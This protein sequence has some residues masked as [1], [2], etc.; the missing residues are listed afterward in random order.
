MEN[1]QTT[2]ITNTNSILQVCFPVSEGIIT[3][4]YTYVVEYCPALFL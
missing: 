4:I 3:F 2:T 1:L